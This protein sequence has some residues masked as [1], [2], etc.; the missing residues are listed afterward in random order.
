MRP[1]AVSMETHTEPFD[2]EAVRQ[3][4]PILQRR[5]NGNPLVYFDNAAT[6]QRPRCVMDAVQ[7]Y[8]EYCNANVHRGVHTLAEEA[9]SAFEDARSRM[10]KFLNAASNR[11]VIFTRGVTE[12]VNLV[13]QAF[14]RPRLNAGDEI[15]ITHMEHH[16]NIVPWQLVCEQTGAILKVLPINQRGELRLET[17]DELLSPRVKM[18]ALGHVSNALGSI[19]PVRDLIASARAREIP[20]LIDGAQAAPHL[21]IDVQAL[22]CDFYCV[23]G[24]KMYGPTGIGVLYGRESVLDSMAP[25]HGGG[26][27]IREVTFKKTTYNDLPAKFEAGTPNI[28]GAIGLGAAARFLSEIGREQIVDYENNLTNYALQA[29]SSIA[30]LRMI[31]TAR[32]RL[33]VLSFLLNDVHAHDVGT[34]LD[35]KGIAIRTGHHCAM[36]V[37]DFFCVP[38]TSRISLGLFNTCEEIDYF[39]ESLAAVRKMFA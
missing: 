30:G 2:V 35:Q 16:S 22:G 5:I 8:F 9:T 20:V 15:L 27:M 31:G 21:P 13:A 7:H 26:E 28:V 24:H 23:S 38:A 18:F 14:A 36:P 19:N 34:L 3:H 1:T 33:G 29:V 6:A 11:E 17:L 10:R 37:M 25:Y 39:V 32:H 12:G 4:F